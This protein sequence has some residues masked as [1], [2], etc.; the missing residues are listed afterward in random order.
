MDAGCWLGTGAS[1]SARSMSYSVEI[2]GRVERRRR[3]TVEQKMAVLSEAAAPEAS[4]SDVARRH[5]LLLAQVFKWRR[6][7]ELGV[8][9]IPGASRLPS[10]VAVDVAA[11]PEPM[12]ERNSEVPSVVVD[13]PPRPPSRQRRP[14]GLIEIEFKDGRRLR[15]DRE[16]DAEAL[17][18]VLDVLEWR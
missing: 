9:G 18:R 8:I 5:G 3:F 13:P 12:P 6:L 7:A 17:R 4:V 10:F 15:V 11:D 1:G 16:V 2:M 14:S